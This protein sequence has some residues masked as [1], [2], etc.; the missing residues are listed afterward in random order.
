MES[1]EKVMMRR[2]RGTKGGGEVQTEGRR[3]GEVEE[4]PEAFTDRK[5]SNR[6]K[7]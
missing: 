5:E 2:T 1:G 7:N 6:N 4:Q 3:G